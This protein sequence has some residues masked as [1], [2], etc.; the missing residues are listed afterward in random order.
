M[1]E[2]IERHSLLDNYW[3]YLYE[4]LVKCYKQQSSNMRNL[5]KTF[6]DR[7]AQLQF[8]NAYLTNTVSTSGTASCS[9]VHSNS[10]VLTASSVGAALEVKGE[11]RGAFVFLGKSSCRVLSDQELSDINHWLADLNMCGEL[12]N[13]CRTYSRCMGTTDFNFSVVYRVGENVIVTDVDH[14]EREWLA[15]ITHLFVYGPVNNQHH[16]FFK[17]TFFSAVTRGSCVS[18]DRGWTNQPFMVQKDYKRLCVYPLATIN[19]KVMLYPSGNG[20]AT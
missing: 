20:I 19:R 12:P 14:P 17:G 6:A 2:D 15:T 3:C 11:S 8:V 13:A 5:C 18:V 7:A 1:P 9:K 10:C 16:I 4:R